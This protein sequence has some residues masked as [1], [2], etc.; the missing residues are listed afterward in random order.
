MNYGRVALLKG[1]FSTDCEGTVKNTAFTLIVSFAFS[2][3][4]SGCSGDGTEAIDR[5][6]GG[7]SKLPIL[8]SIQDQVLSQ[9]D[10][11]KVDVNNIQQGQPG[12][13]EGMTY[14]CT[15]DRTADGI[16][17]ASAQPCASIPDSTV[18][19][20]SGS[21]VL[22]W[23][24]GST[25]LGP[26]EI[27]MTGIDAKGQKYDE[28][29]VV[30]VRLKFNGIS[31][32]NQ[33]TGTSVNVNWT[34]NAVAQGYQ[35]FKL[36]NLT[37][38]YEM[39]HT[40]SGGGTSGTTITGLTPNTG[41][42]FRAQALDVLGN[43]DGNVVSKSFT[44]TELVKFAMSPAAVTLAAG[45]PQVITV[46][47]YNADGSPQ[48]VG[49]MTLTPQIQ[50]GTSS[51]TFS[52]V[53][54]N[55]NGTYTFTF[56]PTVVGTPAQVEVTTNMSFF[57][58]NTTDVTVTPGPASSANTTIVANSSTIVSGTSTQITAT[59]R[60]AYNNP[61]TNA[62]AISFLKTGGTSTGNFSALADQGSGVYTTTYTGIVAGTAQTLR[63]AVSG[64][65]LT[66]SASVQVVPGP[67][68]SA[69]S[70]LTVSSST[71][72]SGQSV[73]VTATLRDLN[74]NPVSSGVLVT[75][76]KAGGTSTGNFSAI[77]NAGNGVYT[78]TYTGVSSGTAQTL[79]VSVDAAPLTPT[80][81]IEVLPGPPHLPNSSL[82]I[83]SSTVNSGSFATITATLRDINNN[84]ISGTSTVTFTKTGGTSTGNFG[85]FVNQGSGVYTI[86]Y[87]AVVAGT[88]QTLGVSVDGSPLALNTTVSVTPGAPSAA[89]STIAVSTSTILSNQAA[90]VTATLR[91]ANNNLIS[92]GVLVGF[93]KTG[94]TSTGNLSSVTNAGSG[95]YTATYTGLTAGTAQTLGILVEG[96][97][98]G[99]TTTL[100]VQP[101]AVHVPNSSM[102]IGS[103]SITSGSSTTIT[104]T[105]RDVNNNPIDSGSAVTFS[106]TGG[107]ATGNFGTVTPQGSG[108]YTVTYTGVTAGTAQ[109]IR[110]LIDGVNVGFMNSVAVTP[111]A[112]NAANSSIAVSAASVQSGSSVTVTA[113]LRDLN[114]NPI[115]TGVLVGFSKIGGTSTGNFTAVSNDGNGVYT[116]TYSGLVAGS[117]QTLGIQVD[118]TDL[119]PTTSITV[120]PGAPSNTLSTLT[121][122]SSTV[123][124]GQTATFTATI[125]DDN[126]NPISSGLVVAFNRSGGTSNGSFGSVVN[127][128]SGVYTVVFTGTT[129]GSANTV[130]TTVNAAP[131][132]PNRNIQVLV[133]APMAANS[134]LTIT[135][136]PLASGSVANISATVRDAYNN[137]ITTEYAISF[138]SV[139][140]SSS[141]TLGS[142]TTGTPGTFLT[143][144]TGTLAGSAQTIRVLADGNPISGLNGPLQV[145]PGPV[146]PANSTFSIASSLVQS[147]TSTN[148]TMNLRDSNNNAISS[149]LTISFQ[150]AA[151]VSDGTISLLSNNG[152]GNYSAV[153]TGTTQGAAQTITLVVNALPQAALNVSVTVTSG[154]PSQISIAGP[155]NPVN[156][157]DCVGPYTVTLR[158]NSNNSTTSLTG[159]TLNL[160]S[161]PVD[162]HL[163]QIFTDASCGTELTQMS[164]P[165]LVA[166]GQFY[167]KSYVPQTFTLTLTPDGGI[168]S[169]STSIQNIP[170]LSWIGSSATFTYSGNG[171][172]FIYDTQTGG[173][174][175]PQDVA[176]RDGM[177]YVVDSNGGRIL[178]YNIA[179]QQY[180]GWLGHIGSTFGLGGACVGS[181]LGELTP[182]WC[183]GG[184]SDPAITTVV[185]APRGITTDSTY[186]YVTAG[187]NRVAR[188]RLTTGAYEGWIGRVSTTLP[189]APGQLA[190]CSG[191]TTNTR[192]PGWC[193]GGTQ[194]TGN[195]D[196][197][198]NTP[199]DMAVISGKLY[200]ADYSNHRL[201]RFDA[202]TGAFEGWI[203]RINTVPGTGACSGA[204]VDDASPTWCVGGTA[205]ASNRYNLNGPPSEVAAPQEGFNGPIGIDTDGTYL[206][207]ADYSNRRI[208][209]I[210][211]STGAYSGWIGR[212]GR[213]S[214]MSPT[215]PSQ[216]SGTYTSTWTQG[217]V[218]GE[219][220]GT[221]GFCAIQNVKY[222]SG[223]L[224]LVD[225]CHRVVKVD[226]ADGGDYRWIGRASTSPTGGFTG[227]S[228]TPI[229]GATPGWCLGGGANRSGIGNSM[230]STP[231]GVEADSNFVYVV[232]RDN[233]R[234]QR[235][236]KSTGEFVGWVGATR[237]SATTWLRTPAAN[238]ARAGYDDYSFGETTLWSGLALNSEFLFVTDPGV[239]RIKK[240]SRRTGLI[241]GY[242]GTLNGLP[243]TGPENCVGYT[244]GMTPDWCTGGGRTTNGSG[245]HGYQSPVSVAADSTYVYIANQSQQRIDRVRI[246]DALYMGWIGMVNATP[247]DGDPAC[248][249]LNTNQVTPAWCIGGT[250]K[251]G[252]IMGSFNTPRGV[253]Y[254]TATSLLYVVANG[255]LTKLDPAT[256][257]SDGMIGHI[258][259]GTGCTVAGQVP[260]GW[261]NPATGGNGTNNYGG[262]SDGTGI[263]FDATYIYVSDVGNHRIHR[264][265][266][267]TGAP[268]GFVGLLQNATNLNTS[269]TGGACDGLTG[270]YPKP[271]PGWC[272]ANN[273][274]QALSVAGGNI[275]EGAFNAPRGLAAR[276]GYLYVADTNNH[277]VVRLVASTGA[278]AGWKGYIESSSG[279]TDPDCVA[280]GDG[281]ITPK[282]CFGGT[283]GPSSRLGGFNFPAAIEADASY[284]YVH[285]LRNNRIVTIPRE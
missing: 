281:G 60:D 168:S 197:E 18:T 213:S 257:V 91:D 228:S 42:T 189:P 87:N 63:V 204:S 130:Q 154:P 102:T 173:M 92:S 116:T 255:A 132:G 21:G 158:D 115:S 103:T 205:K 56:T 150:K 155:A 72:T 181:S 45:T 44:T 214:A 285:D 246:S 9:G 110:V 77:T 219:N 123:I 184:R 33:I 74:S 234:V 188:F 249:T 8:T 260:S 59:V 199:A 149:G 64:T 46:T 13:D 140:G 164:I 85:S 182:G 175:L 271:A 209:R 177:M 195:A 252:N 48:T 95:V 250:A 138:D 212:I 39:F 34:P 222:D 192:T 254:D 65:P 38:L 172:S 101:G 40:V 10:L 159:V 37:G 100:A 133:G 210:T 253:A 20:N 238:F 207:V 268:A 112:P 233:A 216:S 134:V 70:S 104:A 202:S 6:F 217:G 145:V 2:V 262:L 69:Q 278:F 23:T 267:S 29:F 90:T 76:N 4:L 122:S 17:D 68:T 124:A 5:L 152:N 88:A 174:V 22:E 269:G 54:D 19:F 120:I 53:T 35:V 126:G 71:V 221:A 156:S 229:S 7:A 190:T 194:T 143:T 166:S 160:S 201:Q 139:G 272:W 96:I 147:G 274:G 171:S 135:S 283:S 196:G 47:A 83:S 30:S 27:K 245:I 251:A 129:A 75:L 276:D 11:L 265:D 57:L 107:T 248:L 24:P 240:H 125:R 66:P 52:A 32:F 78:A 144:Y 191:A 58:Q 31:F 244:T 242:I 261:C 208:V 94:G 93:S 127:Q 121:V 28:I 12:D 273:V 157:T 105:L 179:T 277:R 266:K 223:V 131:L 203:G 117:A 258:T 36:N 141:G 1:S 236:N 113:T 186:L 106:K 15:F 51:G 183:T 3:F 153:Y 247:T 62:A 170:V 239:H 25:A 256:G 97:E 243:P 79:S 220:G 279:M 16:V 151:G 49:G 50:S 235:F 200:V 109:T 146:S 73:T 224:Y 185:A 206:Y 282:W 284:L 55:N 211:A 128:G 231:L 67:P 198:F 26:Y 43:L 230:F 226:A 193:L 89:Q 165:P 237:T 98:L 163:G 148:L 108:V 169:Q 119:G 111:G 41:Y 86:R 187:N 136:S 176:I 82:T 178:K 114:N 137:P 259:A 225:N 264:F 142:V 80:A 161:T 263:A 118:S 218:T 215:S 162:A 99:P 14:T 167:Y 280:A 61:I 81:T 270:P 84:P 180:V 241:S 275:A 227:C 232:D